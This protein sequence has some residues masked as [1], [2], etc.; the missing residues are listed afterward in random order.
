M[1]LCFVYYFLRNQFWRTLFFRIDFFHIFL[2][3]FDFIIS[4][5]CAWSEFF[6]ILFLPQLWH[7]YFPHFFYFWFVCSLLRLSSHLFISFFW[8]W[9]FRLSSIQLQGKMFS[10]QLS[11][12]H[13][14][15]ESKLNS[16]LKQNETAQRSDKYFSQFTIWVHSDIM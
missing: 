11:N 16:N 2:F 5:I 6:L 3:N 9:W 15:F 13:F 12:H 1:F 14:S 7:A 10:T 8:R 4:S